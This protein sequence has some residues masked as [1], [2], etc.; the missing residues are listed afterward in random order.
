ML[1]VALR[2]YMYIDLCVVYYLIA[3]ITV[4]ARHALP[5]LQRK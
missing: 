4:G 5:V 1:A 3:V 2:F